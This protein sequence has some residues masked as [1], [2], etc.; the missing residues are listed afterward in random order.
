MKWLS[1]MEPLL[2]T[3]SDLNYCAE[4]YNDA[5]FTLWLTVRISILLSGKEVDPYLNAKQPMSSDSV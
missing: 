5:H 1:K 2:D 4:N 3:F